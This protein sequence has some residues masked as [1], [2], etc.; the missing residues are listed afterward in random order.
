M[1]RP[2]RLSS[3]RAA[4]GRTASVL[5]AA[6]ILQGCESRQEAP[7]PERLVF[8]RGAVLA[9]QGEGGR[10]VGQ[11]RALFQRQWAPGALVEAGG[12]KSEAPANPECVPLFSQ[13]IGNIDSLISRDVSAPG[14]A[15]M[16][17]P[18]GDRL[19][20]GTYTGEVIV[21]D[22]WT[23]EVR[24]R[25]KL[26]ETM[27]K[28]VAWSPDGKTLYAGEQSPDAKLH[29]LDPVSLESRWTFAL[30]DDLLTSPPPAETDVYGV[31][32][33]PAVYGLQVLDGG[34]LIVVG[35]HSWTDRAGRK[36][37]L[38]RVYRI[39]P[40]GIRQ[41]AWPQDGPADATLRFPRLDRSAG[42][43]ALLVDRFADGPPPPSL[44]IDGVQVL[45]LVDLTP[46]H[47]FVNQPL[48][49][50]FAHATVWEALD[51]D[52]ERNRVLVGY[53][54]GRIQWVPM[55]GGDRSTFDLGT[56]ITSGEVPIAAS[57][58]WAHVLADGGFVTN[59]GRSNI[60]WGSAVSATRPPVAHPGENTLWVYGA[61]GTLGWNWSGGAKIQ[62]LSLSP[63]DRFLVLGSGP[64]ETDQR[65]DLFGA[66]IFDLQRDGPGSERLLA[67]CATEGP[68]FFQHAVTDDG[69]IAVSELPRKDEAGRIHGS[70][71][72]TVL[73]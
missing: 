51:L 41:A 37:N 35:M 49:P 10:A 28:R 9:P 72:V 21:V 46:H 1:T 54:D 63:S 18:S 60:P 32:T 38:G 31:F 30:A 11:G 56:P 69:R 20:V 53:G 44:P 3:L 33:L 65:T 68:V 71:R 6:S 19:A 73:R 27:V 52:G 67:A 13:E 8:L 39:S 16:W 2:L 62:G 55:D 12:L 26:A 47:Q 7:R 4:L 40:Q 58:G 22:G 42:L 5:L 59:T 36:R 17:S 66:W 48:A 70:Y 14:T 23:G 34:D 45:R 50:H 29:A 64:R 24:S 57:V 43:L 61:D 15:L 25:R